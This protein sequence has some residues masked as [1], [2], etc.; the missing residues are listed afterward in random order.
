MSKFNPLLI[1]SNNG[2]SKKVVAP[3]KSQTNIVCKQI[4]ILG[5]KNK[6][7]LCGP[8]INSSASSWRYV[9]CPECLGQKNKYL[10]SQLII[11]ESIPNDADCSVDNEER[12]FLNQI[13]YRN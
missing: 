8:K 7:V 9:S 1:P 12:D 4:G 2:R 13:N 3:N 6:L 11:R 5:G 10:L